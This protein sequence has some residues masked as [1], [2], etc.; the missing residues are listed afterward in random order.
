MSTIVVGG[1]VVGL[2]IAWS[3]RQRGEEVTVIDGGR[4]GASASGVNA[5]WVTPSLSTPLASPGI[6]STGL[7]QMFKPDGALVIRP[8]LDPSW[9][10]WLWDF[11]RAARPVVFEHGVR[12]LMQLNHR[13]LELFDELQED[14][15]DFEMHNA[16]ILALAFED[17]G[18][19]WFRQLF[20]AL[21]P[22]GFQGSI[23]YLSG[24]EAR[25]RDPAVGDRIKAAAHTEIDRFVDPDGL[26]NGLYRRLTELGVNVIEERPVRTLRRAAGA[27]QVDTAHGSLEADH[28]VVALG[29]AANGLLKSIGT[30]LPVVGAKGY[31]VQLKGDGPP[32]QH[33]MYL[34]EAKLGLSPF[35]DGVRIAGFFELPGKGKDVP[36]RRVEQL[37]EQT[38]PYMGGWTPTMAQTVIGRGGLRPATP[39]SL[40]F[41]GPVPSAPGVYVAAGHGMLGVTLAPA[42]AA[43]MTSMIVDRVIPEHA[44]PFQ[45]AGRV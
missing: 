17:G 36:H 44:L 38:K 39:D 20:Q 33:A 23:E 3:L 11:S 30:K 26:M 24:D 19:D 1:G 43:A 29:A 5:G 32:P 40:P 9:M 12:A 22:M 6:L 18:L 25:Q 31:S 13:T 10:K 37:I 21:Q 14:G 27:W 2:N 35:E 15:V 34:M 45:L 28:V 16:G 7:K 4:I 42:T 41:I 8:R